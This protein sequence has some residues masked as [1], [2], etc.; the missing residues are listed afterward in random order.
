MRNLQFYVSGKR[1]MGLIRITCIQATS[2]NNYQVDSPWI[3]KHTVGFSRPRRALIGSNQLWRVNDSPYYWEFMNKGQF[4]V[5]T[6]IYVFSIGECWTA[7]LCYPSVVIPHC[8]RCLPCVYIYVI[9][10]FMECLLCHF[11]Y[12]SVCK[13]SESTRPLLL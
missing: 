7:C 12:P 1:P 5:T 4:T 3:G 2:P 8:N 10:F 11:V 6:C 13:K 9:P